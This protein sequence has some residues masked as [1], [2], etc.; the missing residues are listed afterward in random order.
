VVL[1]HP[2]AVIA[3]PIGCFGDLE[4]FAHGLRLRVVSADGRQ[5]EYR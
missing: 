4:R 1:G 3:Q 5:I 2:E